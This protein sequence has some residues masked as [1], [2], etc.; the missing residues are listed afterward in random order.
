MFW[1]QNLDSHD[2]LRPELNWMFKKDQLNEKTLAEAA[3]WNH[4][5]WSQVHIMH[6]TGSRGAGLALDLMQQVAQ[7]SSTGTAQ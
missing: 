3:E 5:P 6:F 7:Q 4:V 2:R 1:A